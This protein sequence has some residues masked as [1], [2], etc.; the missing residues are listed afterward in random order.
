MLASMWF[1]DVSSYV[2]LVPSGYRPID[3][4][5]K[6]LA[7]CICVMICAVLRQTLPSTHHLRAP[8]LDA[9]CE[10][11]QECNAQAIM[12]HARQG[13]LAMA[14]LETDDVGVPPEV[15]ELCRLCLEPEPH[16]R[17]TSEMLMVRLDGLQHSS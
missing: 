4:A 10:K 13:T 1:V 11:M 3:Y 12:E 14:V 5:A 15:L 7:M 2:W 9:S 6:L 8:F 16:K 17:I